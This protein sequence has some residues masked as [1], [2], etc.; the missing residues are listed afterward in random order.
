M[1]AGELPSWSQT[2][3]GVD[4]GRHPD[5]PSPRTNITAKPCLACLSRA[6]RANGHREE[7]VEQ[8]DALSQSWDQTFEIK[9]LLELVPLG[10][11]LMALKARELSCL[12]KHCYP[13]S[14][15][16]CPLLCH[17][18]FLPSL[19]RMFSLIDSP[20][21]LISTTS[22]PLQSACHRSTRT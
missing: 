22:L 16:P 8:Q 1:W 6:T 20:P 4:C 14:V 3:C 7:G 19:P 15:S 18:E 11:L 10:Q 17:P 21:T 2:L 5:A 13:I 12:Q 9:V